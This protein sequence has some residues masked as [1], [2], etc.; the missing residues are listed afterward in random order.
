MGT[1]GHALPTMSTPITFAGDVELTN[2]IHYIRHRLTYYI[3]V[4][5]DG[6]VAL[7]LSVMYLFVVLSVN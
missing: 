5:I 1:R 7:R 3:F 4:G 6:Y 2:V